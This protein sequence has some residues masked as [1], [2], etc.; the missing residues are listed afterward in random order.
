MAR[1]PLGPNVFG[2]RS[3]PAVRR[4]PFL[5]NQRGF[6]QTSRSN[7]G[8]PG[9][10][11][12]ILNRGNGAQTPAALPAASSSSSSGISLLDMLNH[13]QNALKAAESFMPMVQ[14][15]GPMVKNLP[16]MLKM[17]KALKDID[18]DEEEES[19]SETEETDKNKQEN[20]E[21]ISVQKEKEK[22]SE[23]KAKQ[24]KSGESLPK[25]YI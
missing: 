2:R 5:P 25:L 22:R 4:D 24:T 7:G 8:L 14:E 20:E 10:L 17:M 21:Q 18:F 1:N 11:Q 16:S 15:Y 12:R 9:I 13:T 3:Q 23:Q 6:E 19:A